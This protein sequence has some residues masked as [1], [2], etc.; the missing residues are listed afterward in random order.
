MLNPLCY[1]AVPPFHE[2]IFIPS[3]TPSKECFHLD[4]FSELMA[5]VVL[6][7]RCS[8]YINNFS[9]PPG[10][11]FCWFLSGLRSI[12]LE[13]FSPQRE[14]RREKGLFVGLRLSE[15]PPLSPQ[16]SALA[17]TAPLGTGMCLTLGSFLEKLL[18]HLQNFLNGT[19]P[20]VEK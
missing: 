17:G 1:F 6:R 9:T 13:W 3:L 14:V 18:I 2:F 16:P 7:E 11:V 20:L 5:Q 12:E 10:R 8:P 19:E 15:N 4:I